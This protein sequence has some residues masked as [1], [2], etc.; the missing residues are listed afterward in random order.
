MKVA[1]F[2]SGLV[3]GGIYNQT[4][5]ILNLIKKIDQ[6]EKDNICI[7]TDEK[8]SI[9]DLGIDNIEIKYFKKS[10]FNRKKGTRIICKL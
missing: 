6:I 7:I 1:F 9:L 8:K 3:S 10:F 5:G 2:I 4:K